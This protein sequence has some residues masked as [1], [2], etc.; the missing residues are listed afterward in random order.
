MVPEKT[1]ISY[2][3]PMEAVSFLAAF[4]RM[5]RFSG[6]RDNWCF[7]NCNGAP[8]KYIPMNFSCTFLFF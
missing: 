1:K 2:L 6:Q 5:K 8:E 7:G 3:A 4:L